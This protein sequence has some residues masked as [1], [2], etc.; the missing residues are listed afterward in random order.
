MKNNGNKVI[1]LAVC[2][3]AL[4]VVSY[5]YAADENYSLYVNQSFPP[6]CLFW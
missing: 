1:T 2:G 4:A 6:E 5:S 3:L